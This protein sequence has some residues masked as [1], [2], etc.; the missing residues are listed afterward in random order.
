MADMKPVEKKD[1]VPAKPV[2]DV[3]PE[4]TPAKKEVFNLTSQDRLVLKDTNND[5][6]PDII[7]IERF[8][9]KAEKLA[10]EKAKYAPYHLMIANARKAA[11]AENAGKSAD[12]IAA[13]ENAAEAK[14]KED[15]KGPVP[16]PTEADKAKEKADKEAAEKKAAIADELAKIVNKK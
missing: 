7:V 6:I 9:E 3:K 15:W 8:D 16:P 12:E 2:E 5:G 4:P 10:A 11:A 1:S 13:A 14:A